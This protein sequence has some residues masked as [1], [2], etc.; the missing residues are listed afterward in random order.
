MKFTISLTVE[1]SGEPLQ[2]ESALTFEKECLEVANIG[3]SLPETKQL[4]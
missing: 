2:T 4:L 1:A 3:L